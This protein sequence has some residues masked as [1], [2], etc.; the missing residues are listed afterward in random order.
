M[1]DPLHLSF[2]LNPATAVFCKT[3]FQPR[4]IITKQFTDIFTDLFQQWAGF[5]TFSNR[6][7]TILNRTHLIDAKL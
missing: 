7:P 3:Y 4:P 6:G 2:S 1:D 5:S